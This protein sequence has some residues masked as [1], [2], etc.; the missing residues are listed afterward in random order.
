MSEHVS[1][2]SPL[3]T[4]WYFKLLCTAKGWDQLIALNLVI[5]VTYVEIGPANVIFLIILQ[6]SIRHKMGYGT[7][8]L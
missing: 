3:A 6:T 8:L 1:L 4:Y 5:F 7:V 2:A